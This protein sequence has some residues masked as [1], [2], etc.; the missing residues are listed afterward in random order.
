M[1]R[2]PEPIQK[3][4]PPNRSRSPARS[5]ATHPLPDLL[6]APSFDP[7]AALLKGQWEIHA[8]VRRPATRR[9][10]AGSAPGTFFAPQAAARNARGLGTAGKMPFPIPNRHLCE[11]LPTRIPWGRE[12]RFMPPNLYGI[13]RGIP[14]GCPNRVD[15]R[16]VAWAAGRAAGPYSRGNPGLLPQL[17]IPAGSRTR[18]G[19]GRC[20]MDGWGFPSRNHFASAGWRCCL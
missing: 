7:A 6:A 18:C 2:W 11:R 15:R 13:L 14:A 17:K 3:P 8:L 12:D 4:H 1:N 16:G 5:P 19:A 10:I 9:H 20:K